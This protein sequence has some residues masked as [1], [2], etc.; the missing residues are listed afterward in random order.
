MRPGS[1]YYQPTYGI[2]HHD[3]CYV[4]LNEAADHHMCCCL[5]GLTTLIVAQDVKV[6]GLVVTQPY[7]VCVSSMPAI[8][9]A[10][11]ELVFLIFGG[12]RIEDLMPLNGPGLFKRCISGELS[13]VSFPAF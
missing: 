9:L 2:N 12:K 7:P 1:A 8:I 3:N 11:V 5:R 4:T 13:F 10:M 6:F